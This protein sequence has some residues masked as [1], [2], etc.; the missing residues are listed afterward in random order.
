MRGEDGP[1]MK[2]LQEQIDEL[3]EALRGLERRL[4][5]LE[6]GTAPAMPEPPQEAERRAAVRRKGLLQVDYGTGQAFYSAVA[7]D[8]SEGGMRLES[9]RRHE[10]GTA[11]ELAF[12]PP[13]AERPIKVKG[14]I[15]RVS[16]IGEKTG[17]P[18]YFLGVRFTE[19]D[20]QFKQAL[21]WFLATLPAEG[22]GASFTEDNRPAWLARI[23]DAGL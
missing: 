21:K 1:P 11:L 18:R 22:G 4:A 7:L 8:L 10:V 12:K 6:R 23:N 20:L 13:T 2:V 9:S 5:A 17:A 14:Q 15:V 3:R 16:E 19:V